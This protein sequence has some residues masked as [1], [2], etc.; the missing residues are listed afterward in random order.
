MQSTKNL[1][2]TAAGSALGLGDM[3]QTQVADTLAENAK[4]KKLS[5]AA[6][7]MLGTPLNPNTNGISAAV[8][9]LLGTQTAGA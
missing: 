6:N 8:A 1:P 3:L 4:K 9:S 7:A 5:G 2:L